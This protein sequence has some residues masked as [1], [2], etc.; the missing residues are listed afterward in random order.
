[1]CWEQHSQ[2]MRAALARRDALLNEGIG[3]HGVVIT[4]R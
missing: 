1:M 2:A 4:G 3:P